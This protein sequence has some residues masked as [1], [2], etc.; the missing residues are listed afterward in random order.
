M[1]TTWNQIAALHERARKHAT[2]ARGRQR[3]L[4]S[5]TKSR[6]RQWL[7]R[8]SQIATMSGSIGTGDPAYSDPENPVLD[9]EYILARNIL[10]EARHNRRS[11]KARSKKA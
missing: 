6:A 3:A 10:R 8:K 4:G 7:D 2:G 5:V 1:I 11:K 9:P